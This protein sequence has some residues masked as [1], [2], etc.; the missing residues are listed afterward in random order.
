MSV[1]SFAYQLAFDGLR[2]TGSHASTG[3]MPTDG[4]SF[5]KCLP[6]TMNETLQCKPGL[7]LRDF[8]RELLYEGSKVSNLSGWARSVAP[9][10]LEAAEPEVF[11]HNGTLRP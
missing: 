10:M 9:R 4:W 3:G 8:F 6:C 7:N 1:R 11:E 2:S 5:P